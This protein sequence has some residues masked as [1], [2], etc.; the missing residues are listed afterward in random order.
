MKRIIATEVLVTRDGDKIHFPLRKRNDKVCRTNSE[1]CTSPQ[2]RQ[3]PVKVEEHSSDQPGDEDDK[4][5]LAQ[6]RQD[7]ME[8]KNDF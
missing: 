3:G 8:A 4:P 5:D 1:V 6:R 7:V 2:V